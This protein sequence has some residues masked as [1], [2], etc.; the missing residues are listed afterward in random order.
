MINDHQATERVLSTIEKLDVTAPVFIRTQFMRGSEELSH[1]GRNEV[2]A[3]EVEGGLEVLS[4]VLRKLEIP[5]NLI[6]REIKRARQKTMSSER[7]FTSSPLPLI[8]HSKLKELK[9][10][11]LLVTKKSQ[12]SEN[13]RKR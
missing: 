7:E 1:Q 13:Q 11:T 6:A 2:V 4:R 5:R 9:V 8:E 12:Y 10:E 3:C